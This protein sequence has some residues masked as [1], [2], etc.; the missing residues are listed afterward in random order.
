MNTLKKINLSFNDR[1]GKPS[2][3]RIWGAIIVFNG[4][5]MGW[6]MLII[7]S[8]IALKTIEGDGLFEIDSTL[9]IGVI[10]TGV[11]LLAS[12]IGERQNIQ[13]NNI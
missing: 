9:I 1:N 4:L 13:Q 11:G 5:L 2:Q 3:K 6:Y 10:T 7:K 12:T 8:L